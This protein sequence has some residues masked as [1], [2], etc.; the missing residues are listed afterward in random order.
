M[1]HTDDIRNAIETA[2]VVP[3]EPEQMPDALDVRIAALRVTATAL[4][5]MQVYLPRAVAP[6]LRLLHE[7]NADRA[8]KRRAA[9]GWHDVAERWRLASVGWETEARACAD[10]LARLRAGIERMLVGGNNGQA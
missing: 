3:V 6:A 4:F 1:V 8:A 10:E 2:S 5:G 7:V 9:D